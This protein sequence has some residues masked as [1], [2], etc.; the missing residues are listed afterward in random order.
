L[1][2]SLLLGILLISRSHQTSL[3]KSTIFH[4]NY[5]TKIEKKKKKKNKKGEE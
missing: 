3:P 1:H 5:F 4:P 2:A